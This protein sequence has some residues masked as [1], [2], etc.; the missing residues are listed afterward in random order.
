MQLPWI[1]LP[2]KGITVGFLNTITHS[3]RITLRIFLVDCWI[4]MNGD[5]ARGP[6]G[7]RQCQKASAWVS[8]STAAKVAARTIISERTRIGARA[9]RCPRGSL[10]ARI[11]DKCLCARGQ[12]VTLVGPCVAGYGYGIRGCCKKTRLYFAASKV[13][14]ASAVLTGQYTQFSAIVVDI[15]SACWES[16]VAS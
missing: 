4:N 5:R 7:C 10:P 16:S 3:N 9:D 8:W 15:E 13:C 14:F 2:I 11:A 1:Q 12:R 6:Q